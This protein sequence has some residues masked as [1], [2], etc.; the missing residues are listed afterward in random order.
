MEIAGSSLTRVIVNHSC[1]AR[2]SGNCREAH[3]K[4]MWTSVF[5]D[6]GCPKS[7]DSPPEKFPACPIGSIAAQA[8]TCYGGMQ[9]Q[10]DCI[11]Q[12]GQHL[13]R[14]PSPLVTL[15]RV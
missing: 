3:H 5:R 7:F 12:D 10:G 13:N 1:G 9:D 14:E 8:T 11:T 15:T 2:A 4:T 6:S